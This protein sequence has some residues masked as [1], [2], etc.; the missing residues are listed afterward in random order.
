MSRSV[1][2]PAKVERYP[3]TPQ[4]ERS[5]TWH[6]SYSRKFFGRVGAKLDADA[7]STEEARLAV[8]AAQA[9]ARETGGGPAS[10]G[11]V[12]QR[13]RRSC[14]DGRATLEQVKAVQSYLLDAEDDLLSE[15][16]VLAEVVPVLKQRARMRALYEAAKVIAKPD[17]DLHDV[18]DQMRKAEEIGDVDECA[19]VSLQGGVFEALERIRNVAR[20]ST[21]IHELDGILAGGP[22]RGTLSFVMADPKRGKSMFLSHLA[23]QAYL[24]G[25]FVAGATLE[26]QDVAWQA[27][28]VANVTSIPIDSVL[29]GAMDRA[30]SRLA[31]VASVGRGDVVVR[32]FTGGV[33]SPADMEDWVKQLEDGRGRKVDVLIVDY[34]DLLTVR[35]KKE[36][37][38]HEVGTRVWRDLRA[39]AI[40]RNMW[41]WTASQPKGRSDARRRLDVGDAAGSQGKARET[42][43]MVTINHVEGRGLSFYVAAN[44]HGETGLVAGPLPPDFALGRVAPVMRDS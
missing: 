28:V 42:D 23:S 9:F 6:L 39:M 35:G 25:L 44:R 38:L 15:A 34:G 24:D 5:L 33:T 27:R 2:A 21:G 14:D 18:A 37:P 30:R 10:G 7:L 43:L 36:L 40:E 11:T 8:G 4:F 17:V 19:D 13:L 16:D 3:F 31:E 1:S 20:L 12:V 32:F 22:P 41:V 29:N 26:I